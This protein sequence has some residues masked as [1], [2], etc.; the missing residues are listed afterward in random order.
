MNGEKRKV[1]AFAL[2]ALFSLCSALLSGC[3]PQTSPAGGAH[4]FGSGLGE[5][6]RIL[7]GSENQELEWILKEC[8]KKTGVNL[9]I[10]YQKQEGVYLLAHPAQCPVFLRGQGW[11][12]REVL[13]VPAGSRVGFGSPVQEFLLL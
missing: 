8:A 3:I 7:S 5:K 9:E 1:L 6:I 13:T 11:L 2:C 4:T 10:T 12:T